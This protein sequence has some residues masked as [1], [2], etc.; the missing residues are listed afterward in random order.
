LGGHLAVKPPDRSPCV[1][2]A[3][4]LASPLYLAMSV[5][6]QTPTRHGDALA[7]GTGEAG[8]AHVNP[9]LS[10]RLT[11]IYA[12]VRLLIQRACACPAVEMP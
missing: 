12:S 10:P 8:H 6:R 2:T 11:L 3:P 9:G 1:L 5:S 7:G 4:A